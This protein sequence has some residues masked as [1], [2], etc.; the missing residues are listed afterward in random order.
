MQNFIKHDFN[1]FLLPSITY[2]IG[3]SLESSK[4][5]AQN[6]ENEI[7]A[8]SFKELGLNPKNSYLMSWR[9]NEKAN[10]V[11]VFF[12]DKNELKKIKKLKFRRIFPYEVAF[13]APNKEPCGVIF[14]I[15]NHVFISFYL[16]GS[17]VACSRLSQP[18]YQE[19]NLSIAKYSQIFG[20]MFLNIYTACDEFLEFLKIDN[21]HFSDIDQISDLVIFK[22]D[23]PSSNFKISL[24]IASGAVLGAL[25]GGWEFLFNELEKDLSNLKPRQ[26]MLLNEQIRLSNLALKIDELKAQIDS[27]KKLNLSLSQAYSDDKIKVLDKLFNVAN[28]AKIG[29]D[30]ISMS[31][32][33]ITLKAI[34]SKSANIA[35]FMDL[36]S[37]EFDIVSSE[38]SSNEKDLELMIQARIR[39]AK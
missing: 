34:S 16:D 3:F 38:V 11:Q 19:I 22:K 10:F 31:G 20:V 39:H 32:H 9:L 25:C 12:V 28:T 35:V 4:I 24:A 2:S 29:L 14:K 17:F 30:S 18:N 6:L 23:K 21:L 1:I 15:E 26:S 7:L 37:S 8:I 33:D 13:K 36:F 27:I 5:N